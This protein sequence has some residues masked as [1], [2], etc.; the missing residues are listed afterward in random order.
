MHN[1]EEVGDGKK[2]AGKEVKGVQAGNEESGGEAESKK[3]CLEE[4]RGPKNG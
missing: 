1:A 4:G 2:E 3:A